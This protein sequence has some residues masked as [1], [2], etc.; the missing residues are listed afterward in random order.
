MGAILEFSLPWWEKLYLE[1]TVRRRGTFVAH[2]GLSHPN[3]CWVRLRRRGDLTVITRIT[4]MEAWETRR[5]SLHLLIM[6]RCYR[7]RKCEHR[8]TGGGGVRDRKGQRLQ[9]ETED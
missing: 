3:F 9:R 6:I 7:P 1:H 5:G 2:S 8:V 4:T